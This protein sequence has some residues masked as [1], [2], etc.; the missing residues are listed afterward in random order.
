MLSQDRGEIRTEIR[1]VIKIF[2]IRAIHAEGVI[3]ADRRKVL[4][5]LVN[6]PV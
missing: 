1:S 4:D 5:N 3:H 6:H 2:D